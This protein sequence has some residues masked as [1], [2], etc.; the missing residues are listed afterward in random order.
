MKL[1]EGDVT[2]T[3]LQNVT[4]DDYHQKIKGNLVDLQV[5][6]PR[7]SYSFNIYVDSVTSLN[8]LVAL[9][10]PENGLDSLSISMAEA[11]F[12][13]NVNLSNRASAD[14]ALEEIYRKVGPIAQ[15]YGAKK[16]T[17]RSI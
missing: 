8:T 5:N 15:E 6:E 9:L 7:K 13:I 4:A 10:K 16:A 17:L 14:V 12:S 11:G 1:T 2:Y 3:E